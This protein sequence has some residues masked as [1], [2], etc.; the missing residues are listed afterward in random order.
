MIRIRF[1]SIWLIFGIL[2]FF[3]QCRDPEPVIESIGASSMLLKNGKDSE[4]NVSNLVDGSYKSWCEGVRGQGIGE[5]IRLELKESTT[6]RK[7]YFVNGFG[8]PR[9]FWTNN[10]VANVRAIFPNAKQEETFTLYDHF[11]PQEIVLKN[12]TKDK[13]IE[14][15]ILSVSEEPLGGKYPEDTCISEIGLQPLNVT[16]PTL[17]NVITDFKMVT[18]VDRTR[19]AHRYTVFGDGRVAG[20]YCAGCQVS[21]GF[22]GTWATR[23]GRIEMLYEIDTHVTGC[24]SMGEQECIRKEVSTKENFPSFNP[25]EIKNEAGETFEVEEWR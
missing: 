19:G 14:L 15:E 13:S 17:Q 20:D 2:S 12:P 25:L 11:K 22:R 9:Y 1:Y 23:N 3:H 6:I 24:D 18:F 10:R 8:N 21:E 7:I 5:K 16:V 4:Y